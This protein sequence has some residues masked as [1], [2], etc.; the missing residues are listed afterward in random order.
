[1]FI[2]TTDPGMTNVTDHGAATFD[3]SL[4]IRP[5]TPLPCIGLFVGGFNSCFGVLND[6]CTLTLR[7]PEVTINQLVN[8]N[9]PI[10]FHWLGFVS[11]PA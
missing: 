10:K 9:G 2:A 7:K 1:M 11:A 6:N 4:E 3:C 5:T 8:A